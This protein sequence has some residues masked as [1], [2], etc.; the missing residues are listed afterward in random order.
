MRIRKPELIKSSA[1]RA[2]EEQAARERDAAYMRNPPVNP[3]E[4]R[5]P[6]TEEQKAR[7]QKDV[8]STF[9]VEADFKKYLE[10]V[11]FD[12]SQKMRDKR[13]DVRP[14]DVD[15]A[16]SEF[17][18]RVWILY[19]Q[20][21]LHPEKRR[22]MIEDIWAARNTVYEKIKTMK[23]DP[24]TRSPYGVKEPEQ[25][26]LFGGLKMRFPVS[27]FRL[28]NTIQDIMTA[29]AR[30]MQMGYR[31]TGRRGQPRAEIAAQ[32]SGMEIMAREMGV[33]CD[34]FLGDKTP[35][36]KERCLC[37]PMTKAEREGDYR[38]Y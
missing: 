27:K 32:I 21:P 34:C 10:P 23:K 19:T 17:K 2:R 14:M 24:L 8:M 29:K 25:L 38:H 26:T 1:T 11:Q 37:R 33:A 6:F 31:G 4:S 22:D 15:R 20:S 16:M 9:N 35:Q 3:W 5:S 13:I 28:V 36:G 18:R 7:L 30:T 12:I